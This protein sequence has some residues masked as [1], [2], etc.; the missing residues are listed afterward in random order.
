MQN[1]DFSFHHHSCLL[2]VVNNLKKNGYWKSWLL[3]ELYID[4]VVYAWVE[5]YVWIKLAS[6]RMYWSK[7]KN[8]QTNQNKTT[9]QTVILFLFTPKHNQIFILPNDRQTFL[10]FFTKNLGVHLHNIFLFNVL[11]YYYFSSTVC[12]T[13]N[14]Y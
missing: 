8:K 7:K 1:W 2:H 14:Q 10:Q 6:S 3:P 13:M 11:Y 4:H 5:Q 9:K 12:F